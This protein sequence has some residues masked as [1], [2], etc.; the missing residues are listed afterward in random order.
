MNS[1]QIRTLIVIAPRKQKEDLICAIHDH[2][3]VYINVMYGKGT[4]DQAKLYDVFGLVSELHKIVIVAFI[5]EEQV[6]ETMLM[7]EK[8]FKFG[9]PNTG[10]AFSLTL[11]QIVN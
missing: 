4:V 10:F 9:E 5:R 8:K 7:L 11:D 3:A 1:K 2:G 6:A